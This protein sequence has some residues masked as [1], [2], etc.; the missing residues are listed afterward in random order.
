[1]KILPYDEFVK[2]PG[3]VV[4]APLY[5]GQI[6]ELC[7]LMERL[8]FEGETRPSDFFYRLLGPTTFNGDE[9]TEPGA[10]LRWGEFDYTAEFAVLEPSDLRE[11]RDWVDCALE[12]TP[13]LF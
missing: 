9:Q 13:L 3:G 4:F 10:V 1:M 8:T 6:K 7:Q 2:L 11:V 5:R 12:V